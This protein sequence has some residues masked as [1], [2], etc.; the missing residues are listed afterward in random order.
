MLVST[1]LDEGAAS[2]RLASNAVMMIRDTLKI[3]ILL[4]GEFELLFLQNW[5]KERFPAFELGRK[6]FF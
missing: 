4:F 6:L 2:R 5:M 3:F 1:N